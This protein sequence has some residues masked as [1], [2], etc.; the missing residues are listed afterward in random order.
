MFTDELSNY[1]HESSG[2]LC[3]DE[4]IVGVVLLTTKR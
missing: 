4:N 1:L 3:P 2:F